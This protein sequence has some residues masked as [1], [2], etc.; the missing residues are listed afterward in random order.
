MVIA[1]AGSTNH[2]ITRRKERASETSEQRKTKLGIDR[3]NTALARSLKAS[4]LNRI[5]LAQIIR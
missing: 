4:Y 5:S 2:V 3:D 1:I